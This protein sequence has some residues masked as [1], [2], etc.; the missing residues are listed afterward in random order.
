MFLYW[1]SAGAGRMILP[2]MFADAADAVG[3]AVV[4][5]VDAVAKSSSFSAGTFGRGGRVFS[6]SFPVALA[7]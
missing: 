5:T 3:E 1:I 4:A 7:C 6:P 2:V